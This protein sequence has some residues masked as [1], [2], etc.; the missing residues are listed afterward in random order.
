MSLIVEGIGWL[1]AAL[2]VGAYAA[3]TMLPL[4]ILAIASSLAFLIYGL[5]LG[6]WPMVGME[7]LLL[8]INVWRFWEL[9]RLRR[10]VNTVAAD[11]PPD[12]SIIKDYGRKRR[13]SDGD[14]IFSQ[15]DSV[16]RLY[17]LERGKVHL[18][19]VAVTLDAGAIFGEI[20]F[21][22]D[23]AQRT[24][25]ARAV[26]DTLVYELDRVGFMRLQFQDPSFG[27]AVMR[28]ITRRLI[29]GM[30]ATPET[31]LKLRTKALDQG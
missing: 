23:A 13:V 27:M 12:F 19:E 10:K 16:D 17:Y 21:F 4:R 29:D 28:T 18:D 11:A 7:A 8:P 31:Y 26:G 15:G 22:T 30:A 1:A 24:A 20:A 6:L 3:K 5:L 9:L 14:T 25:T 2:T